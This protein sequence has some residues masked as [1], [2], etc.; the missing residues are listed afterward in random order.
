MRF[1]EQ[2]AEETDVFC[3][4]EVMGNEKGEVRN[5][6]LGFRTNELQ[7]LERRLPDFHVYYAVT[8]DDMDMEP[9]PGATVHWGVATFVK[10]SH[11]VISHQDFFLCNGR[12]TYIPQ[13][14]ST[15]GYNALCV[16]IATDAFPLTICNMHGISEPGHKRDTPQ[17]LAQSQKILDSLKDQ[18]GEK[19]I[20]G[21]FNL[22]PDTESVHMFE[23][24]G[25]RNLIREYG[26]P[27]T[28]GTLVKQLNPHY[29]NTPL[30]F[31]EFADYTF[32]SPGIDVKA[33]EVP[34]L[35]ISD[36]LPMILKL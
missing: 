10:K 5:V 15:L 29:A 9:I 6:S 28:R 27:T 25:F 26:I 18:A 31:Q 17:R 13:D 11:T 1:V 30:G 3:F 32:V 7:E 22:F 35:P 36:H 12:N 8:Q 24:A 14:Y 23:S 2:R 33:F 19:I 16:T 21:D 20:M 4:Q 34:D